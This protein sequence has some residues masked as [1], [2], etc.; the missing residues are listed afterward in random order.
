MKQHNLKI[1]PGD[2]VTIY[3]QGFG[4]VYSVDTEPLEED[5]AMDIS[6]MDHQNDTVLDSDTLSLD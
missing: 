1:N 3:V 2:S 6:I 4:A 5:N